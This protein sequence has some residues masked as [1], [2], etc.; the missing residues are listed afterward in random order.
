M[1][2]DD[3]LDSMDAPPT[4]S[5]TTNYIATTAIALAATTL[6][7]YL[8]QAIIDMDLITYLWL[9]VGMTL[10]SAIFL[11]MA[12]HRFFESRFTYTTHKIDE[13]KN[14]PV[15]TVESLRYQNALGYALFFS[16]T[17]FMALVL[18]FQFYLFRTFDDRMNFCLSQLLSS[19]LVF[20]LSEAEQKT[21][22]R[23]YL[24][25]N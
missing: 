22:K 5:T 14:I 3:I 8:F 20:W 11:S 6:P 19:G 4:F 12:Y 18:F 16:N 2:A 17:M 13:R 24:G 21:C 9:Y 10:V 15:E 23:E 7:A 25:A 1:P